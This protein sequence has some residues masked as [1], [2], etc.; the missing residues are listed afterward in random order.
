MTF[1]KQ[2]NGRRTAVESRI[3][4][5]L[6]HRRLSLFGRVARL[7]HGV[8]AHDALRLMVDKYDDRKPMAN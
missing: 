6:R 2:S 7:D 3:G 5:I 8:S 1:D 4:N